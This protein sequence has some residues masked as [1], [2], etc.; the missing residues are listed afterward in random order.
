[1]DM[2]NILA[3]RQLGKITEGRCYHRS[4][5]LDRRINL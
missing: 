4:G 1:M 5:G 2:D 3:E